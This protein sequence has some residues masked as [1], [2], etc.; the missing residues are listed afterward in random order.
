M[1]N[2]NLVPKNTLAIIFLSFLF[3]SSANSQVLTGVQKKISEAMNSEYR[4][5][6][7]LDRDDDRD[8]IAAIDFMDIQDDMTIIEF[9]P[10]G[11]AYYTKLL[12]PLINDEGHLMVIDTQATF[13][14]WG[15][16][17]N[18]P[19]F[20][21]THQV[22]IENDYN[23][24]KLLYDIGDIDFGIMPG[25]ADKF[26]YI[27]EYHNYSVDDNER[28]NK[29]V[30]DV[31]RS[32]GE[33]V[34]IDHTRRHMEQED[35]TNFRREDPVDVIYQVQNAGFV[36]DRVSNMFSE[37]SDDLGKE[38]GQIPNMTDRFFLIFRKP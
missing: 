33:Y 38:V 19:E 20:A 14:A 27:R 32:N 13:D 21:M 2:P 16:W 31:L 1:L 5:Q 28:I 11:Q 15:E 23:R 29:A 9:L 18:R 12:G 10:A 4:S 36:L 34:I 8:P 17:K 26:L 22:V 7:E 24:A 25:T 35:R 3:S 30:F 37:P 6:A